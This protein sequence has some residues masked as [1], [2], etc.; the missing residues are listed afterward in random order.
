MVKN[1]CEGDR[2]LHDFAL[3]FVRKGSQRLVVIFNFIPWSRFNDSKKVKKRYKIT[4]NVTKGDV[5]I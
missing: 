1:S 4:A 2:A 3:A 5:L